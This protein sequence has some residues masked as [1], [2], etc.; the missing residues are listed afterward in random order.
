MKLLSNYYICKYCGRP[1]SRS[2]GYNTPN[3]IDHLYKEHPTKVPD[4]SHLYL[5]DVVNQC[6][7]FRERG[8][9]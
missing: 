1:F 3:L 7:D 5:S 8:S 2:G 4:V 9:E 6:F